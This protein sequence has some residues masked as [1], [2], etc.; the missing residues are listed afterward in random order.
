MA[1]QV[2][3]TKDLTLKD[4]LSRMTFTQACE[5][6][7]GPIEGKKLLYAGGKIGIEKWDEQIYLGGDLFRLSLPNE[8]VIVTITMRQDKVKRLLL[9]CDKCDAPCEHLGTALSVILEHKSPLGLAKPPVKREAVEAL[10]EKQLIER[11]LGERQQRAKEETFAVEAADKNSK[12]P[13]QDYLV[14]SKL[15]GKTYRVALRGAEPGDS[16]CTCPDYRSNTLGTCKHI[17]HTMQKIKRRFDPS[18]FKKKP[19]QKET[20]VYLKY[21]IDLA[22]R[23]GTPDRASDSAA[24][25]IG[26]L[27]DVDISDV[28]DL[29]RRIDKL[30]GLGEAVVVYPDAEEFIQQ[31]LYRQRIKN[32]VDEIRKDPK[33]HE[34]RKT[35]L[36]A[37][38]LPYQMDG[39]AFAAGA[40]RAILADDMG[41][42]KTIQGVGV[43]ELLA[44]EAGISRV[45]VICPTS[46]KSQW[47][48]EI[49]KFSDRT[50]QLIMGTAADRAPQYNNDSFFT[51][52]NYEQ[53]LR[54]IMPI[55]SARW[56]L[57]VLDEGQRIKNWEAQTTRVVKS[58]KSQFAL[59][60]SGTPLENRLD[61]LYSVVQFVDGRHLGPGFRFFNQYRITDEKGYVL[62]YKNLNEL[63]AQLK[64]ILLRRTRGMVMKDLPP[65]NTQIIHIPPTEE[66]RALHIANARIIAA[67]TRK[68]YIN[69]MDLLKLR[70]AMMMCRMC[71]DSTYLVDK[72]GP[73]YSTKLQSLDELF[74]QLFVDGDH[75]AVVFSEW[76]KM[77]D[78]IEPLLRKRKVPFVRL[79]GKVPQNKRQQIVNEFQNN[80]KCKV[81]LSTNAGSTGLNLQAADTIV[82]VDLPWNPAVLEQRIARAHRMGQKRPVNVY[83]LVTEDTLEE[84]LLTTIGQKKELAM[85]ALDYD[86]DISKVD[87]QSGMDQLKAKL[88]ILLG[89]L[90]EGHLDASLKREKEAEATR[91][92]DRREK[93][94]DAGGQLLT[95]AFSFLSQMLQDAGVAPPTETVTRLRE[96]LT[97]AAETDEKGQRSLKINLPS[98]ESL[99]QFAE[100][101]AKLLALRPSS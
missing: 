99:T 92:I 93:M 67:I 78:L 45:L 9:N 95:A 49:N 16:F 23:L 84:Q 37:E 1:T 54:D 82:N 27:R 42:G 31:Q 58:L 53:V 28:N 39:I 14:T 22:L 25:I 72:Q 74:E 43:A 48:N 83:I 71:A 60:L 97:E 3:K 61:E 52:C 69:E 98:E 50:S 26:P 35:L 91:L 33:K 29:V 79:E 64:P 20:S 59:V 65:R 7:G 47:R 81:F 89:A 62:G 30:E 100:A 90:P 101:L 13:W 34:L 73:G 11:A 4:K 6:L 24:K 70:Q 18:A 46:L 85:A 19:K 40:G 32:L 96:Q 80:P 55:E 2:K 57:I 51:I 17:L 76:T 41:L 15:S 63:R 68:P 36:K 88:E 56:D 10:D 8:D 12:T 21:G 77:L 87:L 75:K 86:S 94:A 5:L 66:Q 44:R 38:L